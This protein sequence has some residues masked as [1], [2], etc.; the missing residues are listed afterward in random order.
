MHNIAMHLMNSCTAS[1]LSVQAAFSSDSFDKSCRDDCE[2]N[3]SPG[4]A[5]FQLTLKHHTCHTGLNIKVKKKMN[6]Y[7]VL[8]TDSSQC[9]GAMLFN[10]V[11]HFID[12]F[13]HVLR[14]LI[15]SRKDQNTKS[16]E[17][18]II[19]ITCSSLLVA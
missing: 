8:N 15:C 10:S 4:Q 12:G 2:V 3:I 11:H 18:Y 19:T 5:N 13:L 14:P 6:T 1:H 17:K 16:I 7:S 9:A